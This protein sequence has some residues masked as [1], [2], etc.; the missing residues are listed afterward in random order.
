MSELLVTT[1]LSSA[2]VVQYLALSI[3]FGYHLT[4]TLFIPGTGLR[5]K[6]TSFT[7]TQQQLNRRAV[8]FTALYLLAM[9][10]SFIG[11]FLLASNGKFNLAS[12]LY[13]FTQ[14][15]LGKIYASAFIF[16][17]LSSLLSLRANR[18]NLA[19]WAAAMLFLSACSLGFAGHAGSSVDHANAVN[20]MI[21][22]LL[23]VI[24]WLGPL[25]VFLLE[26]KN[27]S[28]E[29]LGLLLRRYS[30]YAL[31]AIVAL[32]FSGLVSASIRLNEPSE[33]LTTY[34]LMILAKFAGLIL[35]AIFGYFQRIKTLN[36]PSPSFQKLAWSEALIAFIVIGIST[37]LSRTA[38]P[39]PQTI[40]EP[41]QRVLALV[42]YQ[43][44]LAE[45][46]FLSLF[47]VWKIDW[48]FLALSLCLAGFY[49]AGVL[50]LKRRKD[51]WP[52]NRTLFWLAGCFVF[53]FVMSAGPA[54]FGK[55]RFDAHMTQHMALMVII[56]PLLVQGAPVTLLSRALP[57]R[58]DGSRSIREWVLAI[59]HSKYARIVSSAPVAGFLFAG[60][61]V[62][63]YF[64]PFFTWAMFTHIGHLVMTI[65]FLL[66]GYLFAWVIIGIDPA[67][68]PI[69]PVLKLITLLVT[70]TFHAFFG[71]AVVSATWIIGEQWYLAL[72]LFEVQE[73]MRQQIAGGSIMW[74]ISEIPTVFYAIAVAIL[75]TK[76]EERRAKQYDR[77]ALRDGD[78]ELKAYNQYLSELNK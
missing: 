67:T 5:A 37:V 66:A 65:H 11:S 39:V 53:I 19:G 24:T 51:H 49:L 1:W 15:D 78:Q 35:I 52:V 3:A 33:L 10:A 2:K 45:F 55:I 22:H 59:L 8:I 28:P 29:T 46:N 77:K 48:G 36:S 62:L 25:I 30:P 17:L 44:P 4:L 42:G 43:P 54:T 73:L 75:W 32:A 13:F 27:I 60:S 7:K 61:L 76:S 68:K 69:N 34:G 12:L 26:A 6:A 64:S 20:A 57:A 47:T 38:P 18:L 41:N 40:T 58:T 63:F 56:P 14:T 50:R 23:A 16:A 74:G 70:L 72:N 31:F 21:I 9:V 71:L